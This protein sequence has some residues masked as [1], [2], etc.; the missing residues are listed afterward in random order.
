MRVGV[1]AI[2]FVNKE[3]EFVSVPCEYIL[4]FYL[5]PRG[6]SSKLQHKFD[7]LTKDKINALN[8]VKKLATRVV[9]TLTDEEWGYYLNA[10]WEYKK[11]TNKV[12]TPEIDKIYKKGKRLGALG[13]KVLGAGGGGYMIFF[14]EPKKQEKFKEKIGIEWVDYSVDYPS[15]H[16]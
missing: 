8:N 2:T 7:K 5:G 10:V 9:D 11:N 12:T 13:G 14:V 1:K 6:S 16:N 15:A 3:R 4:L